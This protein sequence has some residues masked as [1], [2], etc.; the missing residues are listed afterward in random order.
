MI[1]WKKGGEWPI[2]YI[3]VQNSDEYEAK[4]TRKWDEGG[5]IREGSESEEL[6]NNDG[7]NVK[8]TKK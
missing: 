7:Y 3:M 8:E 5:E 1:L 2:T 6:N 4:E